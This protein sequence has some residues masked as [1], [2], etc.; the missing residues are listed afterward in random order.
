MEVQQYTKSNGM[1]ALFK[2][3]GYE[4]SLV[5]KFENSQV[6]FNLNKILNTKSLEDFSFLNAILRFLPFDKEKYFVEKAGGLDI[7]KLS[8][9][10][11]CNRSNGKGMFELFL[12]SSSF[13]SIFYSHYFSDFVI[14]K[15]L[16][17]ENSD[18]DITLG[19]LFKSRLKKYYK[20]QVENFV[21]GESRKLILFP[22]LPNPLG[23][24]G[25]V[26]LN[27][28]FLLRERSNNLVDNRTIDWS[29]SGLLESS[30]LF[31]YFLNNNVS[32]LELF[33]DEFIDEV[34]KELLSEERN[35][36]NDIIIE[37][38]IPLG[39]VFNSK[40]LYQPEFV[41][42]VKC[43]SQKDIVPAGNIRMLS[44]E[45]LIDLPGKRN[46]FRFKNIFFDVYDLFS[47]SIKGFEEE[48]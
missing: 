17:T 3:N 24:T 27:G 11:I 19:N 43:S 6:G 7:P 34:L 29:F 16:T 1:A 10:V 18:K 14:S 46:N 12:G 25:I 21:N 42:Y 38:I 15:D 40:L 45:E 36:S 48:G 32:I 20:T 26:Q 37:K 31:S 39:F 8:L 30:K 44:I 33:E 4:E 47:L 23:I 9:L 13:Y 2:S 22:G 41:V 5:L 28:K 35:R